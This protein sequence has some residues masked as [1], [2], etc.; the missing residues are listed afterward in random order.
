[1]SCP[2]EESCKYSAKRIYVSKELGGLGSG[3][4]RWPVSIVLPDI[5]SYGH[6][7]EA[8]G[9]LLTELAK[10]YDADTPDSQVS[11]QNWFGRCVYESDNDVVCSSVTT[12]PTFGCLESPKDKGSAPRAAFMFLNFP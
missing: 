4:K 8:K 3:N 12:S 7:T 1:L 9:A 11:R 10:D 2:A 6:E 5:E